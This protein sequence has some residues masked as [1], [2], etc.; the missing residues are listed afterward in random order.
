MDKMADLGGKI[1]RLK[2]VLSPKRAF[3]LRGPLFLKKM[4]SKASH[5]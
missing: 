1:G 3:M 5:L 4:D 2:W